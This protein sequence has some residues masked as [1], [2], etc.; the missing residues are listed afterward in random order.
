MEIN[1]HETVKVFYREKLCPGCVE[2]QKQIDNIKRTLDEDR[3][4]TTQKF[5]ELEAERLSTMQKF[6]E[7]E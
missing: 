7:I 1:N 4:N 6:A 3:L 2:L 5:A